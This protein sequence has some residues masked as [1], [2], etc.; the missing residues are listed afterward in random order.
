MNEDQGWYY[1]VGDQ[2]HGPV[3]ALEVENL[4]LQGVISPSTW[5]LVEGTENWKLAQDWPFMEQ[6]ANLVPENIEAQ[7]KAEEVSA[8]SDL[9]GNE[10]ISQ[11]AE[12]ACESE[13][14][15]PNTEP[16][17]RASRYWQI[18][19]AI[20]ALVFLVICASIG[21]AIHEDWQQQHQLAEQGSWGPYP[22]IG[23][24]MD[25]T[26]T[27]LKGTRLKGH[28]SNLEPSENDLT[29]A[30]A[31]NDNNQDGMTIYFAGR[32]VVA[33]WYRPIPSYLDAGDRQ[34]LCSEGHA[35]NVQEDAKAVYRH[36][37]DILAN[38]DNLIDAQGH[39]LKFVAFDD[40]SMCA[41]EE[42]LEEKLGI[43]IASSRITV[44]GG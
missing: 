11:R 33:F 19:A 6:F 18:F 16:I 15:R 42:G 3:T 23:E 32:T 40:G 34:I 7:V 26:R 4:I 9:L 38:G 24:T 27:R 5:M 31:V 20:G 2:A 44:G 30:V 13:L 43:Q 37:K 41:Y 29:E 35:T 8:S 39:T 21:V 36:Q 17:H 10:T 25:D 1:A 12:S 28:L 22:I 14:V